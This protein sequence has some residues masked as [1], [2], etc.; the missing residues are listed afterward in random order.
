MFCTLNYAIRKSFER[1]LLKLPPVS[2][3]LTAAL[4]AIK[5]VLLFQEEGSLPG[6]TYLTIPALAFVFNS[7]TSVLVKALRGEEYLPAMAWG[8][9]RVEFLSRK[10]APIR[11]YSSLTAYAIFDVVIV[12][13]MLEPS[14]V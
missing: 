10:K 2:L 7:A 3:M 1:I 8:S 13:L 9:R 14:K 5:V 11:V 6:I 4:V 12:L